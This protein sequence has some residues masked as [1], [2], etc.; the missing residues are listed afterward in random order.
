MYRL[1]DDATLKYLT[2][3]SA[4]LEPPFNPDIMQYTANVP[5]SVSSIVMDF[6]VNYPLAALWTGPGLEQ[7]GIKQ[8]NAGENIFGVSVYAE[9]KKYYKSYWVRIICE[10]LVTAA[11]FLLCCDR[12][13]PNAVNL[14]LIK[15]IYN[16]LA[17]IICHR[18][19]AVF[20]SDTFARV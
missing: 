17:Y 12:I 10:A 5:Y 14:S 9:N 1:N 7:P 16:Q 13:L 18:A 8:L 11:V 3:A 6:E 15:H 19:V 2:V 20:F 4:E